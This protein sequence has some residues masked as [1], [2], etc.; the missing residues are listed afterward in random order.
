M[1]SVAYV[2]GERG[3][4]PGVQEPHIEWTKRKITQDTEI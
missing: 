1:K 3:A 2:Y 4:I